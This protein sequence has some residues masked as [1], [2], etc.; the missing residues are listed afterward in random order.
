M[1]CRPMRRR[2]RLLAQTIVLGLVASVMACGEKKFPAWRDSI[3]GRRIESLCLESA[4]A[5]SQYGVQT[6]HGPD[7]G[8]YVGGMATCGAGFD[9]VAGSMFSVRPVARQD[10]MA[11]YGRMGDVS[12]I[13]GIQLM[14]K[15]DGPT[16]SAGDILITSDIRDSEGCVFGRLGVGLHVVASRFA[17]DNPCSRCISTRVDA[18]NIMLSATTDLQ[19]CLLPDSKLTA[20]SSCED[21]FVVKLEKT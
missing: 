1:R 9:F 8:T 4:D 13:E 20:S 15:M 18:A 2:A 12:N 7:F 19:S 6:S 16:F 10:L 11:C 14:Q 3:S 21:Y 17:F 5:N